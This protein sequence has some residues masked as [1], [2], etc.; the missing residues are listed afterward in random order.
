MGCIQSNPLAGTALAD[1]MRDSLRVQVEDHSV[2]RDYISD[3]MRRV[4][5]NLPVD[6]SSNDRAVYLTNCDNTAYLSICKQFPH[7]TPPSLRET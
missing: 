1:E 2:R 3:D 4:H 5:P 6:G 7:F